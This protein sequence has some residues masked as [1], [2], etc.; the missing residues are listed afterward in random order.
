MANPNGYDAGLRAYAVLLILQ[1]ETEKALEILSEHYGIPT[2]MLRIG[3]PRRHARAL[4]CYDPRRR[5]ICL[6]S[7]R[8]YHDPFV[9]LHEFYHHLRSAKAEFAGSEKNADRYA[10]ESIQLCLHIYNECKSLFQA[11]KEEQGI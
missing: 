5:L 6:R 8:E 11:M 3:L 9:V 4:G 7:S 2:P 10:L 1:G